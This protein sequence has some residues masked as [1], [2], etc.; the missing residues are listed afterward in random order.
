MKK[1]KSH[2]AQITLI[3]G[4]AMLGAVS[5]NATAFAMPGDMKAC[6]PAITD[7]RIT[8]TNLLSVIGV[9]SDAQKD[10]GKV[11]HYLQIPLDLRDDVHKLNTTMS[12]IDKMLTYLADLADAVPEIAEP[13]NNISNAL[14]TVQKDV[15]TPIDK[16]VSDVVNT[17]PIKQ[18]KDELGTAKKHLGEIE[19]PIVKVQQKV[20]DVLLYT[21]NA[22]AVVSRFPEG[23]CRKPIAQG[24]NE[25]C[26]G[27]D[28]VARPIANA[29][30]GVTQTVTGIE[31][32]IQKDVLVILEPFDVIRRELETVTHTINGIH[33]Q[34]VLMERDLRHRIHLKIAGFTV[35][36]FSVKE[37]LDE[38]NHVVNVVKHFIGL[39]KAEKWLRKEVSHIL[40]PPIHNMEK[41]IR[42]MI[43][44]IRI[45]GMNM[46][47]AKRL[48][49]GI[50]SE[51]QAMKN[52]FADAE[53]KLEAEKN[54]AEA[55]ARS[56]CK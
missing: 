9:L 23:A 13:I 40:H 29:E 32:T 25:Y 39:D 55:F 12:E 35:V 43:K 48:L 46:A 44:S 15:V 50:T 28:D 3:A 14:N 20:S 18:I 30:N 1:H 36:S 19:A 4:A 38:W 45:D 33:H 2:G 5:L 42:H 11:Q 47:D 52:E 6:Q 24:V 37:I 53:A 49:N 31:R 41:A 34:L 17:L 26:I 54:K 22:V 16:M 56:A 8:N 21:N 10:I 51:V 7:V 27:L